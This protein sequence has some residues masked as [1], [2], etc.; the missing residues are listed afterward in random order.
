[1][2]LDTEA[3][4][5]LPSYKDWIA[6]CRP[7][8]LPLLVSLKPA[9]TRTFVESPIATSAS[10]LRKRK[11]P[12]SRHHVTVMSIFEIRGLVYSLGLEAVCHNL[13][14]LVGL[15]PTV[16]MD[17]LN[18]A[19]RDILLEAI[20]ACPWPIGSGVWDCLFAGRVEIGLL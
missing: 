12:C 6:I 3:D 17:G 10:T 19:P 4:V 18:P 14:S 2:C 13:P 7:K 16:M 11:L 5:N 20:I 9:T 8:L 15:E 1:M